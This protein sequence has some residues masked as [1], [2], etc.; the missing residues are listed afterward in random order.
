MLQSAIYEADLILK[1]VKIGKINKICT[2]FVFFIGKNLTYFDE[3]KNVVQTNRDD[4]ELKKGTES[5]SRMKAIIDNSNWIQN[6]AEKS[7]IF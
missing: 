3:W 1:L 7:W 6:E 2:I 5:F 4:F